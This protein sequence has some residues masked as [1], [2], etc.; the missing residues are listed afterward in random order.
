M[1]WVFIFLTALKYLSYI[2][3]EDF[4]R[5]NREAIAETKVYDNRE[6]LSPN[7]TETWMQK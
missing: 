2:G 5:R 1:F 7:L 4:L 6:M 3:L